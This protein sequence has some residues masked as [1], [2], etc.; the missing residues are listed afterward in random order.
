MRYYY[1]MNIINLSGTTMQ[2]NDVNIE[3]DKHIIIQN[4]QK[5]LEDA[6]EKITDLTQRLQK[7]T[8]SD[9]HKK[10]YE[11]NKER[12]KINGSNYLKK[13]KEENPAKLKEYAHRA[14]MNRKE[15][16]M[17]LKQSIISLVK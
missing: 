11:K 14:Y 4:L 8:N 2:S 17:K 3:I 9:G 6:R 16:L 12:V 1:I 15:K 13:L 7:Y 10:Y 5:E